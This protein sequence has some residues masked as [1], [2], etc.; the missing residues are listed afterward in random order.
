MCPPLSSPQSHLQIQSPLLNVHLSHSP[1]AGEPQTLTLTFVL[2]LGLVL[3][4]RRAQDSS[5]GL[6]TLMGEERG[7]SQVCSCSFSSHTLPQL[8]LLLRAV[9]FPYISE[10]QFLPLWNESRN[11][12]LTGFW[13]ESMPWNPVPS[14]QH[15]H[16]S[17]QHLPSS[18]RPPRA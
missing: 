14:I 7:G 10:T 12:Q 17:T 1:V 2:W 4:A 6:K 5:V 13:E 15:L 8:L 9:C 11:L 16:P 3:C 18:P